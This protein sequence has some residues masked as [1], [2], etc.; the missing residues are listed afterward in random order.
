MISFRTVSGR[1]V[2]LEHPQPESVDVRDVACALAKI[3]RFHGQLRRFYSV[4][5]HSCFVALLVEPRLRKA[6]LV[7]DA[8]EAYLNDLSRNLKH[9]KYLTGYRILEERWRDAVNAAFGTF[10]PDEDDAR[11]IKV[12]DD[13]A[14]VWERVVLRKELNW[15]TFGQDEIQRC[16]AEGWIRSPQEDLERL[17][18]DVPPL[19][20]PVGPDVAEHAFIEDFIKYERR[21]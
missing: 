11:T 9:S 1:S 18:H 10:V 13:L 16:C 2:D 4:A 14:A 19:W 3:C 7:H 8:S 17:F 15:E 6:A 12:A 20:T 21:P 5:Q